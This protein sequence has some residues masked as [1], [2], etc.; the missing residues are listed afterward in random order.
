MHTVVVT[1]NSSDDEADDLH[2]YRVGQ[3]TSVSKPLVC[4]L[5]IQKQIVEMEIDTGADVSLI[6]EKTHQQLF[7]DLP[8]EPTTVRL[9]TY[10]NEAITVKGQITVHVQYG[11]QT[12]QLRLIVVCGDGPSLLGRDWLQVIRLDWHN[13]HQATSTP[14]A[15]PLSTLLDKHQSLFQEELGTITQEKAT[16]LVKP[17]AT[18]KFFKAR[19][20][21]FA[22]RDAVGLQ[23]DKLEAEGV[24][25]K[26][27][28]SD[29]A[30]PIVVVPKRDGSYR[31]CGDYKVTINQA[32]DVD[33]YPLPKPE[34]LLA[35]LAGGQKFSKIDLAQA[36]Q[37]LCLD[38]QSKTF[39]T[40]NTH[41]GLYRYTR[42]PFGIASAPAMFQKTMDVILQG[43]PQVC[44][45]L[46]DILITGRDD[47]LHLQHL[48]EVLERLER[49]GLRLK[50]PKCEF[51]K[52]SVEY[53]GYRIDSQ[54]IHTMQSKV[55]AILQA[56]P[57]ENPQ[58]LRSFL[59]LVNYY[60]KFI[61]N[62]ATLV[63][64]LNKLLHKDAPWQW[65]TACQLAFAEAKQAIASSPVLV[66]YDPDLPVTLAT[67]A[68][69]YGVGAVISHTLPD[70]SEH[71]IA[72]ASRTLSSSETNYAQIE[73]EALSLVFG[74]KKFHTYLYGRHFT[75]LT[76]HKPLTTIL[77]PKKGIPPLAAARLQRWAVLLSAYHYCIRYKSTHDHANA[78]CLSRLPLPGNTKEGH[79][80][81]ASIFQLTQIDSLPVTHQQIQLA[82]QR[83][84]VLSKVLTYTRHHWPDDIPEELKPYSNRRDELTLEGNCVLWGIRVIVPNSLQGKVLEELHRNHAG[85][86][87]MKRVARSYVWWPKMDQNIE[88]L[89][90]S[91]SACQSNRDD[92]A[93]APLHPW[94][95]PAKP[96]QRIHID[97][98]G[99]FL[100]KMF[101]LVVDAHSKWPEAFEMPSTTSSATIRVLRHLFAAYGLPLQL[102]S[103][104][105]PQF[106]SQEFSTFLQENGVKHIR[107]AP[108]HPAS[109][110][111]AERFVKTFK[112]AFKAGEQQGLPLQHRLANFLLSYR[113]TPHST[114]NRTPSSLFLNREVRTRLDLL[115]PSCEDQVLSKQAK[116]S[117]HHDQHAKSRKFNVGQQVMARNYGP[118]PKWIPAVIKSHL[119]PL[120]VS[121]EVQERNQL[122]KRHHDQLRSTNVGNTPE[123]GSC[124]DAVAFAQPRTS[125]STTPPSSLEILSSPPDRSSSSSP[126]Y[127]QRHRQP[128]QRFGHAVPT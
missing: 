62:L 36:Y 40:I 48:Q 12:A 67:D 121:V 61:R 111:L 45:Y 76:D 78:D 109:N 86:T 87:Q 33:Q 118:G 114:T 99:P 18:P 88:D 110:G 29:W 68:S 52:E 90:K 63:H 11:Q 54:G 124:E 103:D 122:W 26:V 95:W 57:P 50:R 27:S 128:P 31:L 24:L 83:D 58:Q 106:C 98:A 10:T 116:Q 104:N 125:S 77:G 97:F 44:C 64:P 23:L 21:P 56:P 82:T 84:P 2:L 89:S 74:V 65:G 60:A 72:F 7:P 15:A 14:P 71:P 46:D 34:E 3:H 107:C 17:G 75:L 93:A 8:I 20:V 28:H 120:T 41:K 4:T 123:V 37:Q 119:G 80:P 66:H 126:R 100:G 112:Q 38:E 42:L 1:Q 16:F 53:L 30:A 19:P 113:S 51:M 6:S 117:Q 47:T 85:M 101:F 25:E 105:G 43:I 73:K 127:P 79:A 49:S 13:I 5:Q 9:K 91:C 108:Y 96:W 59:G 81:E 55:E 70:G 69:A 22:I 32:L 94:T 115:K 39:T 102:V 92:P 35:T